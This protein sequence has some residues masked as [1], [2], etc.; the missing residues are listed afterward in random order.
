MNKEQNLNSINMSRI[1]ENISPACTLDNSHVALSQIKGFI[2][3]GL[4]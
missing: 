2:H 3:D 1:L 4:I